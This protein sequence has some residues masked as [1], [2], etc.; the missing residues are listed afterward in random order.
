M[1]TMQVDAIVYTSKSG[2]TKE[3][4]KILSKKINASIYLL[5]EAIKKLNKNSR[6]IYI[7]WIR[8]NKVIGYKE[9]WKKFSVYLVIGCGL[10]DTG[11]MIGEVRNR[12]NINSSVHLFTV[13]GGIKLSSLKGFDKLLIKML[14]SKLSKSKNRTSESDKML[15]LLTHE[16]NNVKE[17]NLKAVMDYIEAGGF[18]E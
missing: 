16:E 10:S 8:A 5:D 14:I 2:H 18:R 13:Q 9:A 11:T 15:Y 6:I 4:A 3:Y 17:E 7:G 12:T 1:N